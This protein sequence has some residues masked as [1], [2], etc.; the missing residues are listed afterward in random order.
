M[1]VAQQGG[2]WLFDVSNPA[3]PVHLGN[4]HVPAEAG[5]AYPQV[6]SLAFSPDGTM[7]AA[8]ITTSTNPNLSAGLVLLWKVSTRAAAGVIPDYRTSWSLA[9]TPDGRSLVVTTNATVDV[10][11]IGRRTRTAVVPTESGPLSS[12][13]ALSPDGR[14]IALGVGIGTDGMTL[15][16]WSLASHRFT[17]TANVNGA[18]QFTSMAFSPDGTQLAA[19]SLDGTLRLWDVRDPGSTPVLI[20]NFS[21]HRGPLRD[22]AFSPDGAALAS[23]SDDGTIGLW[24]TR[25]TIIGGAAN[26][27][28]SL[29]FSPDGKTLAINIGAPG[30]Y[31]IALYSMPAQKLIARLPVSGLAGLA[32]S[33]DGKTLAAAVNDLPIGNPVE[34][35]NVATHRMTGQV[36]THLLVVNSVAFSPDGTLFAVYPLLGSAIQVWSTARLTRVASLSDMPQAQA[37]NVL[38]A[39]VYQ[40]AFSPDGRLLAAAETDGKVLVFSVPGFSLLDSFQPAQ[41]AVSLAFSPNGRELALGAV[42]GN[43]YLYSVPVTYTRLSSQLAYRGVF[44][45]SIKS[46]ESVEFQSSDSLIAAGEDSVVR[47]WNVPAGNFTATI[48]AQTLATHGGQIKSI[49][50]SASLGLLATGSPSGSR[51]WDTNPARV[52]ASICRTLKAPV[53]PALWKEYLPDIPY[54]PVCG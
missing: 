4:L 41:A 36:L 51:V 13:A 19:A 25:G 32:F 45:A 38:L 26:G 8:G 18:E 20:G 30:H 34:L 11:D 44:A 29:A 43:V 5:I 28:D 12:A 2:P 54:A 53:L 17:A 46:V 9:F 14:T 10:W 37:Q 48:P 40:L 24:N 42:N 50:Y 7:V 39:G 47:F 49:S 22:I 52:A 3:H 6:I 16:L 21:G 31:F 33:P 1:A 15:K 23:A 35:W 27:S